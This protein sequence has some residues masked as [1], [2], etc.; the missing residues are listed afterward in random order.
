MI[1]T[2]IKEENDSVAYLP[3]RASEPRPAPDPMNRR[4]FRTHGMEDGG[5][6][7]LPSASLEPPLSILP[8]TDRLPTL[9]RNHHLPLRENVRHP[10]DHRWT[11]PPEFSRIQRFPAGGGGWCRR[12]FSTKI[13]GEATLNNLCLQMKRW[14]STYGVCRSNKAFKCNTLRPINKAHTKLLSQYGLGL[15]HFDPLTKPMPNYYIEIMK[16][17][18]GH[19]DLFCV[20]NNTV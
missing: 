6:I 16:L 19:N 12:S 9:Q 4:R 14:P 10:S 1:K 13:W 15:W 17:G 5:G 2:A 11:R 20:S 3:M 7:F 8:S 18:Q